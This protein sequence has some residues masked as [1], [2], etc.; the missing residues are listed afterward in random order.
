MAYRANRLLLSPLFRVT[1]R[2]GVPVALMA[3]AVFWVWGDE[4]RRT[5]LSDMY[6][7]ARRSI[8]ERPEFAVRMLAIDG[9]AP[10]LAEEVRAALMLDLPMSSFDLDLDEMRAEIEALDPV[11]AARVR[12]RQGGVLHVDIEERR[13]VALWRTP[14]GALW[15]LDATGHPVRPVAARSDRAELPLVS[16]AGADA[17]IAEALALFTAAIP[18]GDRVLGLSR[19]GERRW[20]VVLDRG[21][22]IRL[23][24]AQPGAA[25][26]ASAVAALEHLIARDKAQ[27]L[28][29]RDIALFDM[30]LPGRPT[31]RLTES[32]TDELR[33]IRAIEAGAAL[34]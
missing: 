16:G 4:G 15:S 18:L 28:F 21:Q 7:E 30:R 12:V 27:D 23:P 1:L 32:A 14:E 2:L 24:G 11:A 33:R 9:A 34:P 20:D 26:G 22:V 31:L 10:R 6:H 29:E 13:P 17:V 25:A 19:R 3:G 5:A 8:E